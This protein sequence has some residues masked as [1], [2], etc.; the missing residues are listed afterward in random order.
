MK[1]KH[2]ISIAL[3]MTVIAYG[4]RQASFQNIDKSLGLKNGSGDGEPERGGADSADEMPDVTPSTPATPVADTG[5]KG[6]PNQ[7]TTPEPVKPVLTVTTP[8]PEIKAG[9]EKM[10][11]IAKLKD[12]V[13]PPVVKWEI[14][15]PTGKTDIGSIDQ[16]GVYTSPKTNDKEFPVTII[17]TLISDPTVVGS[18]VIKVLPKEQVF[19]RCTRGN[20]VFPILAQVYQIN[21]TASHLPDYNN[22]S[23]AQKVTTV[24]MDQYAVAPRNFDTG[25]PDVPGLFE[26]F[27]LQTTTVIVIPADGN[28]TFQLNSDD[29]SKLYIDGTMVIDND[30]THQA[31]GTGVDD[32]PTIGRKEVTLKLLKGDHNLGLDYFQG[33]RLRIALELKWKKPGS[34]NFEYVPTE[35]FK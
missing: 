6:D 25:F 26:Y 17:A 29:G 33:P 3:M 27:S 20:S 4:C 8:S 11:A 28:Y 34:A 16:S 22:A 9:E 18:T 1:L 13:D 2:T 21:S 19:A 30:G 7:N 15:G 12:Q 5:T 14:T 32:S 23:Q 24:C 10:Q 35:S 31:V